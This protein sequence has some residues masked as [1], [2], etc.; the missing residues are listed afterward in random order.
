[1]TQH[2]GGTVGSEVPKIPIGP[3][4]ILINALV[5]TDKCGGVLWLC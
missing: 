4:P 5:D 2:I 1:M 3:K